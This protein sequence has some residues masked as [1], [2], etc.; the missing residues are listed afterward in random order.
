MKLQ[1]TFTDWDFNNI[2]GLN[3]EINSGYPY[4]LPGTAARTVTDMQ[5]KTQPTDLIYTEG[6]NL[7]LAGLEVTLTYNDSSTA[8]VA[9]ADFAA[10][11][12]TAIPDNGAVLTVTNH[13]GHTVTLTCNG[14]TA[15]TSS[16]TVNAVTGTA[17]PTVTA[18]GGTPTFAQGGTSGVDLFSSVTAAVNDDGQTFSGA[19]LTVTNV[20]N[21]T[22]YL[23]VGGTDIALTH[24]ASG[25]FTG[26]SY[27]VTVSG[28]TASVILGGMTLG[29][30]AM[31]TLIDGIT[32]KNNAASVTAGNRVITLT[33]V[34]DSGSGN[35]S[36][37]PGIATTV[38]V[39]NYT[40]TNGETMD[41]SA[42]GGDV[43]FI[44]A[45]RSV[46]LNG[47][48][49][50]LTNVRIICEAGVH[51]TLRDVIINNG[52]SSGVC[53][54]TFTGAGSKLILESGATSTLTGGGAAA[55]R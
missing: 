5:I 29:D 30:A 14:Y 19:A 2:W 16:L 10:N 38:T 54:L 53:P 44:G 48:S 1:S 21:T 47:N 51:L 40:P 42:C 18:T 22:E 52:S 23:T 20:S 24:G 26:G 17:A 3:S 9:A 7:N 49:T 4:L 55:G 27:S 12:I 46:T 39:A 31:G 32:Y 25:S 15:I 37:A 28:T 36:A 50:A 34:T 8:D 45:G 43:I 13:N 33:S 6:E 11:G 35:N 41:I